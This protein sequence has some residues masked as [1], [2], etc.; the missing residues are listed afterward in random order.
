MAGGNSSFDVIFT[1]QIDLR[2]N[3]KI[4]ITLPGFKYY[5]S[6]GRTASLQ[7][8]PYVSS[9]VTIKAS[10]TNVTFVATIA[11]NISTLTTLHLSFNDE[12]AIP[13]NG[14]SYHSEDFSLLVKRESSTRSVI[15]IEAYIQDVQPIG[16]VE[17]SALLF[18]TGYPNQFSS[19]SVNW[20]LSGPM[21]LGDQ[22]KFRL[23]G[24]Y[25][26]QSSMLPSVATI[27]PAALTIEGNARIYFN[28]QWIP[29]V[30]QIVLT[31]IN[32]VPSSWDL[33]AKFGIEN[34]LVNPSNG[35]Q[36]NSPLFTISST[37]IA[38]PIIEMPFQSTSV[39]PYVSSSSISFLASDIERIFNAGG[40]PHL[41]QL[42]P[43]HGLSYLDIN[44][45]FLI[46]NVFYTLIAIDGEM[47]TI[48]ELYT[49]P[50]IY[51]GVPQIYVY[52]PPR[53]PAFYYSGSGTTKLVFKYDI[54]RGDYSK[55]LKIIGL[56]DAFN[57]NGGSIL[58]LSTNPTIAASLVFRT[59]LVSRNVSIN[60][61]A[62][63]I[64][65]FFT[66]TEPN[67]YAV[68]D[69]IDFHVIFDYPV[70]IGDLSTNPPVLLLNI[71]PKGQGVAPYFSGSRT[72]HLVFIYTVELGDNQLKQGNHVITVMF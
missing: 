16:H 18:D 26:A 62:P 33:E 72:K 66:Y 15:V 6:S 53:R 55:S 44:S 48:A 49:G 13:V 4:F 24:F 71:Q 27:L 29:S 52:S 50:D 63:S 3:D 38:T 46:D 42:F 36:Y 60:S 20:R 19:F 14:L 65:D 64:I 51:I 25:Q 39:V 67:T 7:S 37:A 58:R 17:S 2:V 34:R 23:P 30:S 41:I 32:V 40:D 69:L 54:K 1:P 11:R 57:L 28:A 56:S 9:L 59:V 5:N 43:N 21:A 31:A 68:G 45:T 22:L 8:N 35:V 10:D 61:K 70:V 47:M 12:V